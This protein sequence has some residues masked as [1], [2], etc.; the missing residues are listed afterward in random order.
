MRVQHRFGG[1]RDD[2]ILKEE[3]VMK[4]LPRERDLLILAGGMRDSWKI[5]GGIIRNHY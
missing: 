3:C 4:I 2:E 1:I 5:D